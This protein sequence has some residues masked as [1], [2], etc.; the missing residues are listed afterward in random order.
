MS[1]YAGMRYPQKNKVQ[2]ALTNRPDLKQKPSHKFVNVAVT[3]SED[4]LT[5][6]DMDLNKK[7]VQHPAA[8]YFVRV[9]G[10]SMQYSGI[11]PNDVLVVDRSLSPQLKNIV[12]ATYNGDFILKR[13]FQKEGKILLYSDSQPEKP[14]SPTQSEDFEIWGVV[15][16]IIHQA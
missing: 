11:L 10:V 16:Y 9:Q 15:T 8:T 3:I 12:L 5:S 2:I 1:I 7:L 6:G 4:I 13:Y 14:I